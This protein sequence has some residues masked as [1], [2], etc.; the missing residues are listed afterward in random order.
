MFIPMDD[1]VS[2]LSLENLQITV[3]GCSCRDSIGQSN[4]VSNYEMQRHKQDLYI[5]PSKHKKILQK[6]GQEKN[7]SAWRCRGV[8]HKRCHLDMT[9]SL[10]SQVMDALHH[11]WR[12]GHETLSLLEGQLELLGGGTTILF[13]GVVRNKLAMAQLITSYPCSCKQPYLPTH[14]TNMKVTC[15]FVKKKGIREKEK[16]QGGLIR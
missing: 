2:Q 14:E 7:V 5:S 3:G 13:M 12:E 4:E 11:G 15:K 6:R 8:P 10:H 1:Y 9:R 16:R